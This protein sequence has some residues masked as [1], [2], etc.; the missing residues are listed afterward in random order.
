M[1]ENKT[2]YIT[3]T[4]PYVNGK[5]HIGFALEI[6]R[7]DVLARHKRLL[8]GEENVFFNTGTDEHGQKLYQEALKEGL[9][10][11]DYVD[12]MAENFKKILKPL[13]I[14]NNVFTRTSDPKHKKSAQKFWILCDKA[15]FIYKKNYPVKYCVGCE[16][17]KQDSDLSDDGRCPEHPNRELEI[18]DEENY[19]FNFSAF[20]DSLLDYFKKN[21]VIPDFRQK[22]IQ[23]F[24]KKGLNDF[25]ISR[26]KRK[27]PWGIEVPGDSEHVMYVWFDALVN[28]ISCLG[29]GSQDESLFE[30]FWASE[31][32]FIFQIAGKDNLRQQSAIWQAMIQSVASEDPRIKK[33]DKIFIDGHILSGGQKMSKSLGNVIDP[34][35]LVDKYGTDALRYF[36]IRHISD[37]EDSDFTYERFA[38]AYLAD[39]V[40][41]LGN[42]TNRILQ[43]SSRAGVFLQKKPEV[44]YKISA[45]ENFAFNA[46][47]E[48]IWSEIKRSDQF[49]TEKKPF[50]KIK[51]NPQEAKKDLQSL[52]ESLYKIASWVKPIMP[53]S[54]NKILEAIEKNEK[55]KKPIF[56]RL[57]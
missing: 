46:E 20:A 57:D 53:E 56:P 27:M 33:S 38:E 29:W 52:L 36:L 35:V 8:L 21:P 40:N 19:F 44:D 41:G 7:A 25:S 4:L 37:R 39:L 10:P 9:S 32:S 5:A 3:T 34:L 47:A 11:Q 51:D 23:N 49:I 48:R 18:L 31:N 14:S 24:V 26:L 12:R 16:L 45:L 55:P 43:M 22:E 50:L 42:L 28:Y 6:V 30:K 2:F 54:S 13:N 15:G 1:T 17:E